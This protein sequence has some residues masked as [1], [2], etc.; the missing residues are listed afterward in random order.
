MLRIN[1]RSDKILRKGRAEKDRCQGHGVFCR[2]ACLG[3]SWDTLLPG[4]GGETPL[5]RWAESL[6]LVA[7]SNR[8]AFQ[9]W[10]SLDWR[11]GVMGGRAR[12]LAFVM[13]QGANRIE[14]CQR[15]KS[16]RA[17]GYSHS[18]WPPSYKRRHGERH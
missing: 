2:A 7:R 13:I 8:P 9:I 15:A 6:S 4:T 11:L 14:R 17:R 5:E 12:L 1:E 10:T 16:G 18:P 3:L